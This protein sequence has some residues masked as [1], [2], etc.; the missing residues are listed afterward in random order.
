M[1]REPGHEHER[2]LHLGDDLVCGA[3]PLLRL[4]GHLGE[5]ERVEAV[6]RPMP[7]VRVPQANA[8]WPTESEGTW[9]LFILL[10]A[11][12]RIFCLLLKYSMILYVHLEVNRKLQAQHQYR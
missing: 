9:V 5:H 8:S 10:P 2:F 12:T 3:V 7:A 4:D 6:R 11:C 1:H